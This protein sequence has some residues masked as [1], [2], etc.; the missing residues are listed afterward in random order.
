MLR[1]TMEAFDEFAGPYML[2]YERGAVAKCI[3][4]LERRVAEAENTHYCRD[5]ACKWECG[6]LDCGCI[7][8]CRGRCG[9]QWTAAGPTRDVSFWEAINY[10][11]DRAEGKGGK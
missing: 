7:D 11:L 4:D 1:M 5:P 3:P 10:T 6:M 8:M 2:R 9:I